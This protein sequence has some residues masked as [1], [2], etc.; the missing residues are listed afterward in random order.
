MS[1]ACLCGQPLHIVLPYIFIYSVIISYIYVIYVFMYS[2]FPTPSLS[3]SQS[4]N[5]IILPSHSLKN[6]IY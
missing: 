3:D 2:L 5:I 6:K 1:H 4:H